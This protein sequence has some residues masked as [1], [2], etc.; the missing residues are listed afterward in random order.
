MGLGPTAR[1]TVGETW[2]LCCS[3]D[4][5]PSSAFTGHV[6]S[7][8]RLSFPLCEMGLRVPHEGQMLLSS[9]NEIPE[10]GRD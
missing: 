7:P 1:A 8:P 5:H 6:A 4:S 10:D 2:E 3:A 9:S